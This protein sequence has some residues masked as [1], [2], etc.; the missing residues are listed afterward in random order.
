M[1]KIGL[2]ILCLLIAITMMACSA[3]SN[4][5]N[6]ASD[7]KPMV[8]VQDTIY[9][10]TGKVIS[11]L[12]SEAILIGSIE[13]TVPQNEPIVEENFTSNALPVGS[14]IYMSESAAFVIYIKL[15]GTSPS[16]F[17]IYEVIQ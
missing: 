3:N 6:G 11:T 14:E 15:S 17:L 9:G 7:Y 5:T 1:K 16:Q 10:D 13:K 8:Y 12:P 4:D 2:H